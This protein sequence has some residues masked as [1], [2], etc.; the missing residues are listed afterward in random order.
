MFIEPV[1]SFLLWC[2]RILRKVAVHCLL[3]GTIMASLLFV[4]LTMLFVLL[5]VSSNSC[6]YL[7]LSVTFSDCLYWACLCCCKWLFVVVCNGRCSLCISLLSCTCISKLFLQM[8]TAFLLSEYINVFKSLNVV[9]NTSELV[10]FM[11][12]ILCLWKS[13]WK[14]LLSDFVYKFVK[15]AIGIYVINGILDFFNEVVRSIAL[16]DYFRISSIWW[17]R[18][19]AVHQ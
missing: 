15:F 13:V 10:T 6:E 4:M 12:T 7:I 19:Y 3:I 5:K 14:L 1:C 8:K 17:S 16:Q 11:M 18:L 2:I 9:C